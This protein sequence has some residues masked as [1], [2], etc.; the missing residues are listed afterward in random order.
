MSS[1]I[2]YFLDRRFYFPVWFFENCKQPKKW[3]LPP[4]PTS[5]NFTQIFCYTN[6]NHLKVKLLILSYDHF[7]KDNFYQVLYLSLHFFLPSSGIS[8][9]VR[10]EWWW[11]L[12]HLA[13]PYF[14]ALGWALKYCCYPEI[15]F[16][17]LTPL[18]RAS[19]W[20]PALVYISVIIT[21]ITNYIFSSWYRPSVGS[22]SCTASTLAFLTCGYSF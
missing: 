18:R 7:F 19:F 22:F 13:R 9:Y 3:L 15:L 1:R 4:F 20:P 14:V 2:V 12:R 5:I 21:H 17:M 8:P 16:L 6:L 11:C 10:T